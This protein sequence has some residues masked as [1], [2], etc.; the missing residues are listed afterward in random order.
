M[1]A[2]LANL[3]GQ[4]LIYR[5]CDGPHGLYPTMAFGTLIGLAVKYALDKRYIF[6]QASAGIIEDGRQ[7]FLYSMMGVLTTG[8]FWA[9]EL[10]FEYLF[11]TLVMRYAG[12]SLG[13]GIGYALKYQ[14]DKRFVFARQE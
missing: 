10:T 14:L 12:A 13:L 1:I 2:T 6:V 8:V 5:W 4:D 9:F 11:D 3:I 7:F